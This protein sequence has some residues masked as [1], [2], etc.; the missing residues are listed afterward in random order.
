MKTIKLLLLFLAVSAVT[1][2]SC[3]DSDPI[4][5][6]ATT[7]KSIALRTALNEIKKANNPTGRDAAD[8]A[9]C[10]NFVYPITLSLSN[11]T[12]VTVT[13][14]AG[15]LALLEGESSNLYVEGI[16]FPFQVT[17]EGA[18]QTIE[19]EEQFITLLIN[20]GFSTWNDD[21]ETS[22]CFD[23]VFP[24]SVTTPNGTFEITTVEQFNAYLNTP[25]NGQVQINFP[26]QVLYNGA[27]VTVNNIYEFYDMINNCDGCI[28]TQEFMPVCVQTPVGV[29]TYGN[30]CYALCAGY[31][32][33]DLV[34]CN[35][36][37]PCSISNLVV[38][39]GDCTNTGYQLTVDFDYVNTQATQFQ[40]HNASNQLVGTYNLADLPVHID[41]WFHTGQNSDFMTV[42]ILNGASPCDLSQQWS[43]PDCGVDCANTCPTN[44]APVCVQTALGMQQFTNEC[45]ALCA[46]FTPADFIDCG[47]TQNNF[48]NTLGSCFNIAYPVQIQS[49]GQVITANSDGDVLQYWFPAQSSI[50]AFVYPVTITVGNTTQIVTSQAG[51]EAVVNNCN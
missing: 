11:G 34:D 26:V 42:S 23:I 16:A 19:N 46:G 39:V 27:S 50:P 48:G 6:N 49:Q 30:M 12:S 43:T 35:P 1:L 41:S 14:F 10:F 8:S 47:V 31:S 32:Q 45:F 22:Y 9:L 15:L 4:D 20:C 7:Q 51:F 5:N 33:N 25:A 37:D 38:T 18:V 21:L 36:G 24:V 13:S 28:C 44:F 29:I 17:S 3:S 2:Y 40:V